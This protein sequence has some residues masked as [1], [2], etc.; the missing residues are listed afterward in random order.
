MIPESGSTLELGGPGGAGQTPAYKQLMSR[1]PS[2]A[3]PLSA[4]TNIAAFGSGVGQALM[5]S[6]M[7]KVMN[8]ASGGYQDLYRAKAY[9]DA[10]HQQM[11]GPAPDDPQNEYAMLK[12][13]LMQKRAGMGQVQSTIPEGGSAL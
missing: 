1:K 5:G 11:Q 12:K 3:Q 7:G 10:L 6:R 4:R 2:A 8:A 9:P 13:Q